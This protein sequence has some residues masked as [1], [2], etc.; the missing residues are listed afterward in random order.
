MLASDIVEDGWSW[1]MVSHATCIEERPGAGV[2]Q[3]F[4][5]KLVAGTDL[6][7]EFV[8]WAHEQDLAS[9]GGLDASDNSPSH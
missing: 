4:N 8:L 9:D 6:A 7:R 2:I 3:E 1:Q 5:E